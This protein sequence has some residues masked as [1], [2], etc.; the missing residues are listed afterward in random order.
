MT[1]EFLKDQFRR[2]VDLEEA[3]VFVLTTPELKK[4]ILGFSLA[5]QKEETFN[6]AKIVSEEFK[7]PVLILI[8]NYGSTLEVDLQETANHHCD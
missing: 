2:I 5:N 4:Q 1:E 3:V 8:G 6:H 7:K